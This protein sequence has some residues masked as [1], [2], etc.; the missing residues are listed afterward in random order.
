MG[1]GPRKPSM[2][3]QARVALDPRGNVLANTRDYRI[4][5]QGV[6]AGGY[7]S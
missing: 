6:A 4:G 7:A 5:G 3:E 2:V 1:L